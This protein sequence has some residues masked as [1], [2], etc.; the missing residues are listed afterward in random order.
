MKPADPDLPPNTEVDIAQAA[1]A[2][3]ARLALPVEKL[4]WR[5]VEESLGFETTRELPACTH[6]IGQRRAVEALRM[7]LNL[8]GTGYNIF[9]AGPGGT[10]RATTV[11]GRREEVERVWKAPS[12]KC[13][14]NNFTDPDQPTLILL[15]AGEG[16]KFQKAMD[17]LI[18][19]LTKNLPIAFE[20]PSYERRRTDIVEEFKSKSTTR[21]R[22]FERKVAEAG[23]ALVQPS[24]VA[25]PELVPLVDGKPSSMEEL[26]V[27]VTEGRAAKEYYDKLAATYHALQDELNAVVKEM[28]KYERTARE[29]LAALDKD[30]ARP[31]VHERIAELQERFARSS[32]ART[33]ARDP[34]APAVLPG[35]EHKS[36]PDQPAE[37]DTRPGRLASY[38]DQVENAILDDL[39]RFLQKPEAQ[40]SPVVG[41][42]FLEFR[43]NVLVDN[44]NERDAPVIFETSPS[45][46]NLFGTIE[47]VW[48]RSGQW[49][50][51][52][53]KIKAGS[54]LRADGGFLVLNALDLFQ[55]PAVWPALKRTLRNRAL[56]IQSYDPFSM[57]ALSAL[58]PE[59]IEINVKVILIGDPE[60]YQILYT[61]DDAFRKLFK[62]RADFDWEMPRN[63]ESI[64]QYSTL[65]RTLCAKEGM[66][67]FHRS[68]VAAAIEFGARLSGR[69]NKLSTQFNIIADILKEADYWAEKEGSQ[70]VQACH[71]KQAIAKRIER[72]NLT[73]E[74]IQELINEGMILIATQGA[75]IGQ[76]NGLAVYDTGEL[77]F[78][79]P[80]RITAKVA[81]GGSG[82]INIERESQLSGRI[83]D[84][85]VL[86][87]SG[88]LRDRF[89]Q[90][91]P[92]AM[93]ASICF[94]QSYSGVEGDSASSA[95]VY[96][97]LSALSGLPLRQDFAVTGSV[98][99]RGE[100]QPIGGVNQKIE[101]FFDTCLAQG[102]TGTQGVIIP[103]QNQAD[104]MLREDVLDAVREGK[105]RICAVSTIEE[106]IELL[107]GVP[108][109][110]RDSSGRYP[111]GTVYQRADER[112]RELSR[113]WQSYSGHMPTAPGG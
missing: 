87:L 29:L 70:T 76:V 113:L 6:I 77:T 65:I 110:E 25:K 45:Y 48:D 41:D 51:D 100:I 23:F 80:A 74:K 3:E 56:E 39:S 63:P 58:K 9:V 10:G 64:G 81:V 36:D 27:A 69:Q 106:G 93:N 98:N 17:G 38:L 44:S 78:G 105:F 26:K 66:R 89:A 85:G 104:L 8:H 97:L 61:F 72:A 103:V 99:Q 75:A 79:K 18:E 42:P 12:D 107:T 84:K 37:S 102:L 95:E 101:G 11:R 68:G 16:R 2:L 96:A 19:Y 28:R 59:P 46:K 5:C 43:V 15:P 22:E 60:I 55:E 49:R 7:G 20:S 52:F 83:H 31:I 94:E 67:P 35:P 1:Q 90:D 73:Q 53:T 108:A 32:L 50:T 92:L 57:L 111:P 30:V 33:N 13:Y 88:F 109:G 112:L 47:R 91:K 21:A 86:I 24:P 14:V 82:V 4:R 54:L 71:V 34:D 62:I 40:P